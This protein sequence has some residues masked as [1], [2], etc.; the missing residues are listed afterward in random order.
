[1]IL[2]EEEGIVRES[3]VAIDGVYYAVIKITLIPGTYY[4]YL[5]LPYQNTG[6]P[7]YKS[8]QFGWIDF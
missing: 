5:A 8:N 3:N 7:K 2:G 1:M 6:K 4:T